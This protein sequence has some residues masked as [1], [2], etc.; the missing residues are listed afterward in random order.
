MGR[1]ESFDEIWAS[2]EWT[3]AD[4]AAMQKQLLESKL[5]EL[6]EEL[7]VLTDHNKY[8][9]SPITRKCLEVVCE[10]IEDILRV[11]S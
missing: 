7:R 1:L 2:K 10:E 5:K 11:I 8:Y 6:R 9:G 4:F 3:A